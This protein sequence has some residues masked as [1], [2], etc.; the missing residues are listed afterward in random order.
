VE[1]FIAIW[2][3]LGEN[4]SEVIAT[5]ALG[6]A[7]WQGLIA[8]RHNKISVSPNLTFFTTF[9][10]KDPH[11]SVDIKNNGLGTAIITSYEIMLDGVTQPITDKMECFKTYYKLNILNKETTGGRYFSFGDSI[12]SGEVLNVVQVVL[13][14]GT[15][16]ERKNTYKEL[17]RIQLIIKYKSLYDVS[18]EVKLHCK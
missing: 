2:K 10:D 7:I 12:A 17:D 3:L 14:E 4:T 18:Y 1:L 8:R 16:L 11:F 15:F 6:L 5:S 9:L 13:K